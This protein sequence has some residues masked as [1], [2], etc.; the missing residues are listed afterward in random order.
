MYYVCVSII[1]VHVHVHVHD[2]LYELC[3]YRRLR[4]EEEKAKQFDVENKRLAK[5]MAEMKREALQEEKRMNKLKKEHEVNDM[6]KYVHYA[7]LVM[8]L[9]SLTFI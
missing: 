9:L 2:Y 6:H 1:E 3:S 8:I 7:L 5:E 4:R